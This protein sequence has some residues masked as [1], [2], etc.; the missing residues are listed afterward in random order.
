MKTNLAYGRALS[1][2]DKLGFT[3]KL[4]LKLRSTPVYFFQ[5]T[6]KV[7]WP[8]KKGWPS[9]AQSLSKAATFR[10]MTSSMTI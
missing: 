8:G 2:D 1:W 5:I 10:G 4:G 6:R 7:F 3:F 9:A